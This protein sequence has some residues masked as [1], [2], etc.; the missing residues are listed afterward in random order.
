MKLSYRLAQLDTEV[1]HVCQ[2][3]TGYEN[4]AAL[5]IVPAKGTPRP[6]FGGGL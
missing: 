3:L 1:M 6:L 5:N 2:E 4:G